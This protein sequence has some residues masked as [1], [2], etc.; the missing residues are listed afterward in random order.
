MGSEATFSKVKVCSSSFS[1]STLD[2]TACGVEGKG[3]GE[4]RLY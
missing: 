1:S 3:G 4:F 2:G